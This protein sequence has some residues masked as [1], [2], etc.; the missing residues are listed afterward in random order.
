M[1]SNKQ[2]PGR[3]IRARNQASIRIGGEQGRAATRVASYRVSRPVVFLGE[4][5]MDIALKTSESPARVEASLSFPPP[6]VSPVSRVL[7]W[8][9]STGFGAGSRIPDGEL[10]QYIK[11]TEKER[12]KEFGKKAKLSTEPQGTLLTFAPTVEI[13]LKHKGD[14]NVSCDSVI[15]AVRRALTQAAEDLTPGIAHAA[16]NELAK[17]RPMRSY[18]RG[19]EV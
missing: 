9:E 1:V 15:Q 18:R 14:F 3:G 16:W 6:L 2:A 12:I 13:L 19:Q 17:V 11:A 4:L 10:P 8:V 5:F 7:V